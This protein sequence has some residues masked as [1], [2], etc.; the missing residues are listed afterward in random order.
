MCIDGSLYFHT[1]LPFGLRSA[2]LICQRTTRSVVH[3]LTNEGISV[4]VYID[5]YGAGFPHRSQQSFQRM[6]SLFDEVGVLAAAEKDTPPCHQMNC[7]GVWINTLDITLSVP[8][9]RLIE[10]QQELQTWLVKSSFKKCELQRLLGKLYFVSA[11]VR[12]GRA[13]MCRLSNALRS[14][15]SSPKHTSF[16]VTDEL[17]SDVEW[18]VFFLASYNGIPVL[19]S[20]TLIANPQLFA[21]DACLTGAVQF[22]LENISTRNF[23]SPFSLKSCTL[24]NWSSSPW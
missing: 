18:W 13:F 12:P 24:M 8:S 5:F 11:F 3:I 10:V 9:F 4:D 1:S 2:T 17:H 15:S 21:T 7:L 14:C 6:N 19:P 23:R 22:V 16:P 20:D